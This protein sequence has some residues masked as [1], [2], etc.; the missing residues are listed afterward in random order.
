MCPV[1]H[2]GGV[3]PASRAKG[4][5]EAGDAAERRVGA[6]LPVWNFQALLAA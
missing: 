3:L 5:R 1:C 6:D 2:P 4:F